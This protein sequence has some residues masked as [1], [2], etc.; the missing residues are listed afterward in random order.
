MLNIKH[1]AKLTIIIVFILLLQEWFHSA[2]A[3]ESQQSSNVSNTYAK[4]VSE[5]SNMI[6]PTMDAVHRAWQ[7]WKDEWDLEKWENYIQFAEKNTTHFADNIAK[8]IVLKSKFLE[9][10]NN[11]SGEADEKV[12]QYLADR[13]YNYNS[14]MLAWA[15]TIDWG[16]LDKETA[17]ELSQYMT[18][19][20]FINNAWKFVEEEMYREAG[21]TLYSFNANII[22]LQL[23]AIQ[24]MQ[25]F[26]R[27]VVW[28]ILINPL[29]FHQKNKKIIS[30]RMRISDLEQFST[31]DI[32]GVSK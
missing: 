20:D 30:D 27:S 10:T 32:V 3:Q 8:L 21:G 7:V 31:L 4:Y 25:W 5:V 9:E 13:W 16:L 14:F 1:L 18:W 22:K 6:L 19:E 28:W 17:M 15:T 11:N 24:P 29:S 26:S 12:R 23:T 2:K